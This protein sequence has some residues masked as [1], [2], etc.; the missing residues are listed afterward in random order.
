MK[1]PP[2][3]STINYRKLEKLQKSFPQGIVFDGVDLIKIIENQH[4]LLQDFRH[5]GNINPK[6]TSVRD[7]EIWQLIRN[8]YE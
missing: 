4:R 7:T 3:Q 2:K 5:L 6:N 8:C 1:Y